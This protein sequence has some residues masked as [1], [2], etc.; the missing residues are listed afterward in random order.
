ML[1]VEACKMQTE[2][3][4]TF[5]FS[6]ILWLE[7]KSV[8]HPELSEVLIASPYYLAWTIRVRTADSA[9]ANGGSAVLSTNLGQPEE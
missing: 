1:E 5:D 6:A 8:R 3:G 9:D 7:Q 4:L 2:F